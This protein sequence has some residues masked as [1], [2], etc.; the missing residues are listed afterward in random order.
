MTMMG[1]G[2]SMM[3]A[4]CLETRSANLGVEG[5]AIPVAACTWSLLLTLKGWL[6]ITQN[7]KKNMGN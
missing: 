6:V 2:L 1:P 5:A 4:S 7:I 3:A